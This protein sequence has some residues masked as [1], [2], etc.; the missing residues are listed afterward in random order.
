MQGCMEP[1]SYLQAQHCMHNQH[2]ILAAFWADCEQQFLNFNC[3]LLPAVGDIV[4]SPNCWQSNA[5]A[6]SKQY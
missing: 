3:F 5:C 4:L 1:C 2:A 6:T